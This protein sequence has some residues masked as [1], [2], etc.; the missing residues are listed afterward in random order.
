VTDAGTLPA[1]GYGEHLRLGLE[2]ERWSLE[3]AYGAWLPRSSRS[4]ALA[5]AGGNFTL[6]EASLG[7]CY[8]S[9]RSGRFSVQGCGGPVLVWMRGAGFGVTDSGQATALWGALFAE[10]ALR[11]RATRSVA[12]R[13]GVGGLAHLDRP[14]FALRNVGPVHRPHSL[15]AQAE[16]GL[17]VLF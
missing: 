1:W 9:S 13:L 17:E 16:L 8:Q 15:A 5:G 3:L 10:A 6:M 14:R 12:V 11:A 7:G 4:E 2:V